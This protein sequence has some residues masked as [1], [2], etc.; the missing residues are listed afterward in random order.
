MT[1]K[2]GD[3]LLHWN[4]YLALD[5]DMMQ[6]SR[7][8][9][10]TKKNFSTYSIELAHLLLATSSEVDVLAKAICQHLD[11]GRRAENINHY[12]P[13]ITGHIPQLPRQAV[14][15]PRFSLTMRPWSNSNSK[16]NPEWWCSYNAVKH[17]RDAHFADAN[18]K[19]ALNALGALLIVN[20]H[21]YRLKAGLDL[22]P[23]G[24]RDTTRFLQPESQLMKLDDDYYYA[25]LIG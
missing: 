4:Y 10:F 14:R 23:N 6:V 1:I 18:L 5:S 21:Y 12:R 16:V 11:S 7:F 13:I 15:V 20:F 8:V 17:H 9:E 22:S 3:S 19:N 25:H 24:K 2:V